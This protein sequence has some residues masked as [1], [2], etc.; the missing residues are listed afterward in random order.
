M[1]ASLPLDHKTA[2]H[3]PLCSMTTQ[4][5]LQCFKLRHSKPTFLIPK[6]RTCYDCTA[7]QKRNPAASYLSPCSKPALSSSSVHSTRRGKITLQDPWGW[8]WICATEGCKTKN[9]T[10][11]SFAW[12]RCLDFKLLPDFNSRG[13]IFTSTRGSTTSGSGSTF[14]LL[15]HL[16]AATHFSELTNPKLQFRKTRNF[17]DQNPRHPSTYPQP[18]TPKS[19]SGYR[20][21]VLLMT[22][23][24][25]TQ[26]WAECGFVG[27]FGLGWTRWRGMR[28]NDEVAK[29]GVVEERVHGL[30]ASFGVYKKL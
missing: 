4:S 3:T 26:I 16:V 29:G 28:W 5:C 13:H 6:L 8:W 24:I 25:E 19:S 20:R 17:S 7:T 30:E 14:I 15:Q 2:S 10:T 12:T 18:P 1:K 27:G 9:P 21:E 22:G 11:H 23:R